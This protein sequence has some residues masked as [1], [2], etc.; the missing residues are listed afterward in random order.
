MGSPGRLL[1]VGVLI[2]I[3]FFSAGVAV[4]SA[5]EYTCVAQ[6]G[7]YGTLD[8]QF[9][10]PWGIA[11]DS[12]GYV[13]VTDFD[14]LR[15][16][17]FTSNGTYIREWKWTTYGWP[18]DIVVDTYQNL[19][20]CAHMYGMVM[21]VPG[22]GT[23]STFLPTN[24]ETV[25]WTN[26]YV[27]GLGVDKN[28]NIYIC[29]G[30]PNDGGTPSVGKYTPDWTFVTSWGNH[31]SSSAPGELNGSFDVAVDN[32][33]YVYVI[34]RNPRV[35]KFTPNG[36]YLRQWGSYGTGNGEF[37][38]PR[39]IAIDSENNVYVTDYD[40]HRVQKFSSDGVYI[41]QWGSFGS[42]IGE[43]NRPF[44]IALDSDGNVYV[45]DGDNY[46]VQKFSKDPGEIQFTVSPQDIRPYTPVTFD[47]SASITSGSAV[48]AWIFGDGT[49]GSGVITTHTYTESGLYYP[50][51]TITDEN[52]SRGIAKK[53]L[54]TDPLTITSI[55]PNI[56]ET[57]E[58][59][60]PA[61]FT[62]TGT[63]FTKDS[64]VKIQHATEQERVFGACNVQYIDPEHLTCRIYILSDFPLGNWNVIVTTPYAEAKKENALQ[65]LGGNG[66]IR[67]QVFY[68]HMEYSKL[69]IYPAGGA[70][71]SV[72]NRET[73]HEY[74]TTANEIGQYQF[75]EV[76]VGTYDI[77]SW[78]PGEKLP[79]KVGPR[80]VFR[81][82]ETFVFLPEYILQDMNNAKSIG[83]A[84]A[85]AKN[86]QRWDRAQEAMVIIREGGEWVQRGW[87]VHQLI[88]SSARYG[89]AYRILSN[90]YDTAQSR[91]D[92]TMMI[93]YE[94]EA[95]R[96]F[97]K[98]ID[99]ANQV[100]DD[101]AIDIIQY[102]NP[103][104]PPEWSMALEY[105][106]VPGV[107]IVLA[108]T[109][110][111]HT[112]ECLFE[113]MQDPPDMDYTTIY[114]EYMPVPGIPEFT[115]NES[116]PEYLN[117]VV[118]N[119]Q[120][121][122]VNNY[123]LL[124]P[125][126][127]NTL[128][129]YEKYQGAYISNDT[130]WQ[131]IQLNILSSY[132]QQEIDI[133]EN[134]SGNII[135]Y[136]NTLNEITPDIDAAMA[137]LQDSVYYNG[138]RPDIIANL[139]ELGLTSTEI[140]NLRTTIVN[141]NST[142]L[143]AT[144]DDKYIENE[145][146]ITALTA[147][148][149]EVNSE[150]A[151]F[152]DTTPPGDVH[153]LAN[154]TYLPDSITWTWI[155]PPDTDFDEVWVEINGEYMAMVPKGVQ[156][157]EATSLEENT[158]YTIS[159]RTV[160]T[161]GLIGTSWVN[162]TV[163]TSHEY[164]Y[165]IDPSGLPI[166]IDNTMVSTHG[167]KFML[168]G[169]WTQPAGL[170][171]CIVITA[172]TDGL[173]FNGNNFILFGTTGSAITVETDNVTVSFVKAEGWDAGVYLRTAHNVTVTSN[174]LS[175]IKKKG[176]RSDRC[177]DVTITG[178]SLINT[179]GI[180]ADNSTNISCT[181]YPAGS[182]IMR[183]STSSGIWY[184]NVTGGTIEDCVLESNNLGIIVSQSQGVSV[185]NTTIDGISS[186]PGIHYYNVTD[187]EIS[188]NRIENSP[189]AGIRIASG[190]KTIT[191]RDNVVKDNQWGIVLI[192]NVTDLAI[193]NNLFNNTQNYGGDV[194][195][196]GI[197]WNTTMTPGINIIDGPFL[198]GNYWAQPDGSGYSQTAIDADEDGICDSPFIL[199]SNNTDYYPLSGV[200]P[201]PEELQAQFSANPTEGIAPLEVRFT[202][203]SSGVY[204][205]R[206]WEFDDGD[207]SPV[208]NP[209][210]V[211]TNPG[212]YWVTLTITD[213][214][215]SNSSQAGM[216]INVRPEMVDSIPI[217]QGWN[218][219]SI[220]RHLS[221]GN[222]TA[223][224][225]SQVDTGG[226]PIFTYDA[227]SG[228]WNLVG[229]S[230]IL[231]PLDAYWIYSTGFTEI[232]LDYRTDPATPPVK[233]LYAGWN[234]IGLGSLYSVETYQALSSFGLTPLIS[235]FESPESKWSVLLE[236]DSG[237]Q[238][239]FPP[240]V[241]G[242][243]TGSMQPGRG[244]WIYM[245]EPGD[246]VALTG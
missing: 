161:S 120:I 11:V 213:S 131:Q 87:S 20:I 236:Y 19:Y 80:E 74:S 3:T 210:H 15:I 172:N 188:D 86:K 245:K 46:R 55:D 48:Y 114:S 6:W 41:T 30:N 238:M 151:A 112:Q 1:S 165:V 136:V 162:H 176:I 156:Y 173:V 36:N 21:K 134:I 228:Q 135:G 141:Y 91:G 206:L 240:Q 65:V 79:Q 121:R 224:I 27:Y 17:K 204:D 49:Q 102:F 220:P 227:E 63:G 59:Y 195:I 99:A 221:E 71:V 194:Q 209:V 56:V 101:Y 186:G 53:V 178:N 7:S 158:S 164:Y 229:S 108:E 44:G 166:V 16:Q 171:T 89:Q 239:Y 193:Y 235:P 37:I 69:Y 237:L 197:S 159:T 100:A 23:P 31:P 92:I 211:F 9:T 225:F 72:H 218:F 142:E 175:N 61:E 231:E 196:S 138:F 133:R 157:Y 223:M 139:T 181:A 14:T 233:H 215:T 163:I 243:S 219:I 117:Q 29:G 32:L 148:L 93:F 42:G 198:G 143:Y 169:D 199:D 177:G 40:N 140:E 38:S 216:S 26:Y 33:G 230:T 35:Q 13:Y 232:S 124:I 128:R 154:T 67:G 192:D 183:E 201:P 77:I 137:F 115:L 200:A 123:T 125:A 52:G 234:A 152:D 47:A 84:E 45:A 68:R 208:Q 103:D 116:D 34:D 187:G 75:P 146:R 190:T 43:F 222:N 168:G 57:K 202:D 8:G 88:E 182:N 129:T 244:Y 185:R 78:W 246:L 203:E 118:L 96:R 73:G 217:W 155:D 153:A 25:G 189:Y 174:E 12:E 145:G 242:I 122:L 90:L 2:I 110:F 212:S 50:T 70:I 144:L 5:E 207:S 179:S 94:D 62:I 160:D 132:I 147:F 28:D 60:Y 66:S 97:S 111:Y 76:T 241:T 4:V 51:L 113:Y 180:M 22:D 127:N 105:A 109:M 126:Q 95:I 106:D 83:A 214:E 149:E 170:N 150:I 10:S 191:I 85:Y 98:V 24:Y 81:D 64:L 107:I 184:F 39:Y 58:G 82:K 18:Q 130:E 205:T 167:K 104:L 54:V 119:S 226:R